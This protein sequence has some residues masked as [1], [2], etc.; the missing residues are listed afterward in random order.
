MYVAGL[1]LILNVG[2]IFSPIN[3]I[4]SQY[5]SFF[6]YEVTSQ[7]LSELKRSTLGIR[8]PWI[9]TINNVILLQPG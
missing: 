2:N 3:S 4:C 9:T 7:V 6:F 5:F 1:R 8:D